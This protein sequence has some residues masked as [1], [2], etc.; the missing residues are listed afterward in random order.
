MHLLF[1]CIHF[2]INMVPTICVKLFF[3]SN[4]HNI[5]SLIASGNGNGIVSIEQQMNT[6]NAFKCL[7]RAP[8][9]KL[10]RIISLFINAFT[11]VCTTFDDNVRAS[12][13]Y[14][15]TY[16]LCIS[17]SAVYIEH[18]IRHEFYRTICFMIVAIVLLH[19]TRSFLDLSLYALKNMFKLR[20]CPR[21]CS[22]VCQLLFSYMQT[23]THT[24]GS[25]IK[26]YNRDHLLII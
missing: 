14:V 6:M 17:W 20:C 23:Q 16:I 24:Q 5:L 11:A 7:R 15:R 18:I 10:W 21:R 13:I 8:D 19:H 25:I 26:Y 3:P 4:H 1:S 2:W 9:C 12:F 22:P